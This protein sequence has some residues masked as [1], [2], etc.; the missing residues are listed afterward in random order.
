MAI[1]VERA[2]EGSGAAP[3]VEPFSPAL[4][5]A[6]DRLHSAANGAGWCRCVAW[7]TDTWEGW[8]ERTAEENAALRDA[9]CARGEHDG[10]LMLEAGDEPVAW[11]QVGPRDRLAKLAR[12]FE[13]APD[14]STWAVTCFLVA[15]ARRGRGLAPRLLAEVLERLRGRG[16]RRVEAF[17]KRGADPDALDLWNGPEAMFRAA[18]FEVVRDDPVRPVLALRL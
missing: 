15:P 8:G 14:P 4:R 13:L 6:F 7:W 16:V 17:P 11:C 12:Q 3:R 5:P 18:G 2:E 10:Y 9:L 1:D